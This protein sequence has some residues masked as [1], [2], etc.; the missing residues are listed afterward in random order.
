MRK[1]TQWSKLHLIIDDDHPME[2]SSAIKSYRGSYKWKELFQRLQLNEWVIIATDL[3][4]SLLN[5]LL[6]RLQADTSHVRMQSLVCRL[7]R[8]A[9]KYF[10]QSV[11]VQ[12]FSCFRL[13]EKHREHIQEVSKA[14]HLFEP[15]ALFSNKLFLYNT[16]NFGFLFNGSGSD[17]VLVQVY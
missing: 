9:A 11:F 4:N 10:G 15:S 1:L 5:N 16:D 17:F 7:C 14:K 6:I 8:S 2:I 3:F 13:R 12:F